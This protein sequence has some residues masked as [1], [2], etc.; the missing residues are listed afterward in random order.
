M[1]Q[2]LQTVSPS[3]KSDK[4]ELKPEQRKE[5]LGILKA[6][7]EKNMNRHRGL[8]WAEIQARLEANTDKTVVTQRN[9]ENRR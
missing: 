1:S 7:F 6:R 9:G 3:R 4:K 2:E 5:L 8:E